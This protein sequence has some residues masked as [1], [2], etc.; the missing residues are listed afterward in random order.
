MSPGQIRDAH[1]DHA[2]QRARRDYDEMPELSLTVDQASRLWS[3]DTRVCEQLLESLVSQQ[4][5]RCTA[6]GT[7][8]RRDE[9]LARATTSDATAGDR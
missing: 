9:P 6:S 3:L 8:V 5:L 2:L 1:T 7:F 4:I